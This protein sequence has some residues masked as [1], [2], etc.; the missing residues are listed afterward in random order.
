MPSLLLEA[1][2]L[3]VEDEALIALDV[4]QAIEAEK[5]TVIGPARS[6][7]E[8]LDVLAHET[9]HAAILDR[10]LLDGK[11]TPV[12]VLL[13]EMAIPFIFYSGTRPDSLKEEFPTISIFQKPTAPEHLVH[14]LADLLA[15]STG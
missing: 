13:I 2:I 1:R 6:V 8:A 10:T 9:V 12:A 4:S 7:S 14:A 11:A 15:A 3:V 5:G